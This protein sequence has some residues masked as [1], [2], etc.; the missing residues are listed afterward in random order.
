MIDSQPMILEARN[1]AK[2]FKVRSSGFGQKPKLVHAVSDV[3]FKVPA[4]STIGIVGESG[5]GKSTLARLLMQLIELDAGDILFDGQPIEN[6]KNALKA[7]RRN[8]QMVFQDSSASLNPRLTIAQSIAFGPTIHGVESSRATSEACM[9]LERVGLDPARFAGRYPN[10]LSGG[11]RQRVNIARAL[12]LNPRV[13]ILDEAVSALDKSVE[14]QVLNLLNEIK[15]DFG[16]SYV[17]I[18]H[19]LSVVRYISDYV[20]VMYLGQVVEQGP[21]EQ[22]YTNPRH[23]YSR[24]LMASMPTTDPDNRTLVPPIFGDPPSPIDLPPGCRFAPRCPHAEPKCQEETPPTMQFD[25]HKVACLLENPNSGH[26]A[27]R[28]V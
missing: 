7:F 15:A 13:A 28:S 27:A 14:A 26:S 23:P 5:C 2:T 22:I 3:S 11:Q 6:S 21:V 18:S 1:L 12:A 10:E 25:R 4:G 17:F 16:L 19:D 24:A 20:I 8:V 9:L